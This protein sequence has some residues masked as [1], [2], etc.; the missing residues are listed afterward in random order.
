MHHDGGSLSNSIE[1]QQR[2]AL[3]VEVVLAD[4]LE[5]TQFRLAVQN[6]RVVDRPQTQTEPEIG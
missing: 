5:P 1:E 4:N 3:R 2:T 6:V